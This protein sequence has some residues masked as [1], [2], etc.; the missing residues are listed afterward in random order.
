M[1]KFFEQMLKV[2]L[3]VM[4]NSMDTIVKTM[5]EVQQNTETPDEEENTGGPDEGPSAFSSVSRL[6]IVPLYEMSKLPINVLV[7]TISGAT[8]E[9]QKQAGVGRAVHEVFVEEEVEEHDREI[10]PL[11]VHEVE[12]ETEATVTEEDEESYNKTIW[13]IGRPGRNNF[14]GKWTTAFDYHLGTDID[15]VNS[16]T[17]PHYITV[18]GAPKSKGATE[19]LNIH[20]TLEHD[21]SNGDL[22]FIYDR[23]GAEKDQ[24]FV[25]NELLAPIAGAGKGMFKHVALSLKDVPTGAHVITI[26]TSG[27]TE[28]RGHRVDYMK[29][30]EIEKTG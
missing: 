4:A 13:Q 14:Q 18:Q 12:L 17:V 15:E 7:E 8:Q 16:P 26:T 22:I 3:N 11:N 5:Q 6:A 27:E 19:M 29:L 24:V 9:I 2:S 28:A 1:E 23:W 25:D 21:Y 10:I 30:C 20:F